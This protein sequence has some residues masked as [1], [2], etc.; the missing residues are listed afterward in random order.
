MRYLVRR[1]F[2]A[3]RAYDATLAAL[4]LGNRSLLIPGHKSDTTSDLHGTRAKLI[5]R[6]EFSRESKRERMSVICMSFAL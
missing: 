6:K 3:C 4:S 2:E 1:K 5:Y